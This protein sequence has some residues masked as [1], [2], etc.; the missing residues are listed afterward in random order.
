MSFRHAALA[1]VLAIA[2]HPAVS[3]SQAVEPRA[4]VERT[5]LGGR[6]HLQWNTTSA[7]DGNRSEFLLRRARIW[8]GTRV[9]DWIDGAVQV[10][11]AGGSASARYAFVRLSLSPAARIS[12]GQLKRAVD[13]FELTSSAAGLGDKATKGLPNSSFRSRMI[14]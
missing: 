14:F 2:A 5:E 6:L 13:V 12:F 9:N 4:P 10:D 7:E 1:A 8:G 3:S 11:M